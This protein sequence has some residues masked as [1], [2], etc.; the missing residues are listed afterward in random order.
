MYSHIDKSGR[1]T[2]CLH[3][4]MRICIR[5]CAQETYHSPCHP[6][7]RFGHDEAEDTLEAWRC[8]CGVFG[9][10]LPKI[11]NP[12][13]YVHGVLVIFWGP[14]P[15]LTPGIKCSRSLFEESHPSFPQDH[16]QPRDREPYYPWMLRIG[17]V[18]C[19]RLANYDS[20]LGLD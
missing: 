2:I 8:S 13:G 5:P 3:I 1:Y 16:D 20:L 10:E 4:A 11:G 14:N 18:D 6:S 9:N 17:G 19:H 7:L 15:G 12:P